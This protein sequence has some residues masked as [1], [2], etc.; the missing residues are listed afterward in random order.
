MNLLIRDLDKEMSEADAAEKASQA[1]YEKVMADSANRRA[2]DSKSIA[3]KEKSMADTEESLVAAEADMTSKTKE[4]MA[5]D[6]F[7]SQL[8][9]EC[10]WLLSNFD[11]RKEARADEIE[12]L[13][14]AKA[15]LSGAD[16]SLA[17]KSKAP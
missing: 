4:M 2:A 6:K 11:L 15:V 7:L 14:Q 3:A 16:F 5:T 17:Q 8:H 9:E 10:D 13:T 12:A 1:E